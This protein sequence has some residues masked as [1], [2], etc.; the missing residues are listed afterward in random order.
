MFKYIQFSLLFL[1]LFSIPQPVLAE[2][3]F[4]PDMLEIQDG[5]LTSDPGPGVDYHVLRVCKDEGMAV[6]CTQ[7]LY[8]AKNDGAVWIPINNRCIYRIQDNAEVRSGKLS[9]SLFFQ[10]RASNVNG[11]ESEWTI[12]RKVHVSRATFNSERS[13]FFHS[14]IFYE[15]QIPP[16][17]KGKRR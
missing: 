6:D 5:W 2:D 3:L 12:P 8:K 13:S 16:P 11:L 4:E 10:I 1:F 14:F 15:T 7:C 9:Y 17:G